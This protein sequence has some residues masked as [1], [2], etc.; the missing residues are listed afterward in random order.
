[1]NIS[2]SLNTI[3]KDEGLGTQSFL[4]IRFDELVLHT[5]LHIELLRRFYGVISV[6]SNF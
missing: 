1:M 3:I 5:G 4:F 2:R 6:H